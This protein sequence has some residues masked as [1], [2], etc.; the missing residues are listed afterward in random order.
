MKIKVKE[1]KCMNN[2]PVVAFLVDGDTEYFRKLEGED[3]SKYTL[4]LVKPKRSRNANAYLWELCGQIAEIS[5]VSAEDVY[6]NEV[7]TCGADNFIDGFVPEEQFRTFKM[8]TTETH[9][10]WF[11]VKDIVLS[12][13]QHYRLYYGSSLFDS[14]QMHKLLDNVVR[15]AESYGI[16]TQDQAYIDHLAEKWGAN[17]G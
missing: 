1:L 16:P 17:N 10:G 6:R 3:L 14:S 5:G 2:K 4:E 13:M 11:I 15:E 8:V 12:G 9:V 7:I